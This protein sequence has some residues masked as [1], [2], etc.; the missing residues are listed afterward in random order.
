MCP[1]NF[2]KSWQSAYWFPFYVIVLFCFFIGESRSWAQRTD[3]K[4]VCVRECVRMS[5]CVSVRARA[6]VLD[7]RG[8]FPTGSFC[9]CACVSCSTDSQSGGASSGHGGANC[10]HGPSAA[11]T[12]F[13]PATVGHRLRRT[14]VGRGKISLIHPSIQSFVQSC[15]PVPTVVSRSPRPPPPQKKIKC[16]SRNPSEMR[17]IQAVDT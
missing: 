2:R 4:G 14:F 5:A 1:R 13:L 11:A 12:R 9:G 16:T 15:E 8:V 17:T 10:P 7:W 6:S 3:P